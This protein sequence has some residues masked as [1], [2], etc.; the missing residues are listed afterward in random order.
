[1]SPT[2]SSPF[3]VSSSIVLRTAVFLVIAV[4]VDQRQQLTS[5]FKLIQP[6]SDE[7]PICSSQN[8][9]LLSLFNL[10]CN[11]TQTVSIT[12]RDACYGCFFRAGVLPSGQTQLLAISQCA[13]LYLTNSS[14]GV[15]ASG[16]AAIA[17]GLRPTT[18]PIVGTNCYTGYCEFVQCVRRINANN[19]IDQCILQTLN[20]RDLNQQVQRIAF[21]TNATSCILARARCNTYNPITGELQTPGGFSNPLGVRSSD[22]LSNSLQISPRG[23]IRIISFATRV[24]VADLFCSSRSVLDQSTYGDAVC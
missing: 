11:S 6:W 7:Q 5:A 2:S 3:T 20:N 13:T 1:M 21:Y 12:T 22:F 23:D 24:V 16:L 10:L 18:A 19:L 9:K 15:C 14:Y 17:T 4:V 8:Q